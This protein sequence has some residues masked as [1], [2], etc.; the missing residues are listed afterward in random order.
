[1]TSIAQWLSMRPMAQPVMM[2]RLNAVPQEVPVKTRFVTV[3]TTTE[4]KELRDTLQV[5]LK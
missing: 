1:M 3:L 4:G 5:L 2:L